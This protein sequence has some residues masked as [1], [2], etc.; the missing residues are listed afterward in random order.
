MDR[1]V[2]SKKK[3]RTLFLHFVLPS[4][5]PS[6]RP[7]VSSFWLSPTDLDR[8]QNHAPFIFKLVFRVW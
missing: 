5:L 2:V 3:D 4:P 6:F 8:L 1:V 7:S